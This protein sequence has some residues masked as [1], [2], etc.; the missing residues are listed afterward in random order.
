MKSFE[1]IKQIDKQ[2]YMPVFNRF[3]VCFTHGQG[4]KLYDIDGKEYI[5][6][7]AGIAVNCLGHNDAELV[8]AISEQAKNIIHLSNLYYSPIQ[9][10]CAKE[11]LKDTDFDKVFFCNSGA[12]ANEGAIKLVR[13]YYYNK[14]QNKP[15]IITAKNSFHGRTLA[16]AA[17]TGQPKYSQSYKP[18]PEKFVHIPFNDINAF[19]DAINDD[20]G[21]VML[22]VIQGEGGIIP[23]DYEYIQEI[24]AL[25][26]RSGILL[27]IDEVQTGMGRTGK[28]FGYEHYGITP[29]IIT[30]AKGLGAGMPI[31]AV[32]ARGECAE[33]FAPGD[34]GSTFGG[35]PLACAAAL[36][37]IKRLKN[38][39]IDYV[40][41]S[42]EY[43]WDKLQSLKKYPAV[44][45]I[46]GKGLLLGLEL[47]SDIVK[48]IIDKMLANCYI[49]IGCG[50]NS[51]RFCPP[52]IIQKNH[53]D[54]MVECLEGI[55]KEVK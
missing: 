3:D 34:H 17:A 10:E 32:L 33:A 7:G 21:A 9:A 40:K 26:K 49:I 5:D 51:V 50:A 29:D 44:K 27:I 25:C 55:L 15:V 2:Y 23:A 53:I 52:L 47:N 1:K 35:N 24:E 12:E 8:N 19:K 45:Q 11:L 41:Q 42:G 18:L 4:C 28:M 31:G 20:V 54:G 43:F 37:V 46:R 38:G 39:L 6:F 36:V 22:E 30:L 48:Y 13:K 16:T 14:G